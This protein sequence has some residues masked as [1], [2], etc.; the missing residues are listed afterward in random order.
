MEPFS[1]EKWSPTADVCAF[2]FLLFEIAVGRPAI[3][4]VGGA[5]E[6]AV[7]ARVPPFVSRMIEDGRSP[8]S[9]S[10]L[11]FVDIVKR[12]KEDRFEIV[13]GVDSEEV[14]AFVARVE[15]AEQSGNWE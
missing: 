13:P 15:S 14:S 8:E 6:L 1:G 4:P 9:Q 3:P 7:P 5:G 2:S 12:L 10:R 11:S